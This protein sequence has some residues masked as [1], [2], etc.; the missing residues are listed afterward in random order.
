MDD[1]FK[2]FALLF[3]LA[4][5]V[6]CLDGNIRGYQKSMMMQLLLL[7]YQKQHESPQWKMLVGSVSVFNEEA[8]EASFSVLSR[9]CLG[10]TLKSNFEHMDKMYQLTRQYSVLSDSIQDEQGRGKRENGAD[11][12]A[13][14]GTHCSLVH[15]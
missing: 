11:R 2:C 4:R 3:K 5:M 13:N 8:G 10:D 12:Q 14:G 15:A 6:I 9:V 7:M 1:G